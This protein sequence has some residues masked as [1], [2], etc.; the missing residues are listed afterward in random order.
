MAE[1]KLKETVYYVFSD[2]AMLILALIAI[3]I[4]IVE[5]FTSLESPTLA[6]IDWI[7]WFVFVL[8]FFLKVYVEGDFTTYIKNNKAASAISIIIIASPI[9]AFATE[10]LI[11]FP[12]FGIARALRI[13]RII[14]YGGTA[15]SKNRLKRARKD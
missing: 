5:L 10:N 11:P 14:G 8:E 9:A 4:T 7:I 2:T 15:Y 3:P 1:E 12:V 13:F 6:F